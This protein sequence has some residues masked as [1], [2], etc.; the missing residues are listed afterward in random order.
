MEISRLF[1]KEIFKK[2]VTRENA[3]VLEIK[4]EKVCFLKRIYNAISAF[5]QKPTVVLITRI[6]LG[7]IGVVFV[8]FGIFNGGMADVLEKAVKICTQC[9][10]LG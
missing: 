9:I 6:A 8:V 7:V 2:Q 10:G 4:E 5:L 3:Q 1:L